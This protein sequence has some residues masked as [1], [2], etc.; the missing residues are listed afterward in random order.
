MSALFFKVSWARN[1][2]RYRELQKLAKKNGRK[3]TVKNTSR[4]RGLPIFL[5]YLS[6][7]GIAGQ[8]QS[9]HDLSEVEAAIFQEAQH[10]L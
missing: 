9:F 2:E 7:P 3:L 8:P 6:Q 4:T 5:F 10:D 1:I